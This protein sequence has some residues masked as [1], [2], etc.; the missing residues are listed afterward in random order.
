MLFK[1]QT[2]PQAYFHPSRASV[3]THNY[4]VSSKSRV[5]P[6]GYASRIPS[7]KLPLST[8]IIH[9]SPSLDDI[10]TSWFFKQ[11]LTLSIYLFRG[12]TAERLPAHSSIHSINSP[13]IL[14]LSTWLSYRR[15]SSSIHPSTHFVFSHNSII[16]GLMNLRT[17]SILLIPSD[18]LK[19]PICTALILEFSFSFHINI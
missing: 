18:L 3:A 8:L 17:L 1:L 10:Q 5:H 19:L 15:I 2:W 6:L 13:I 11:P 12:R 4:W 16:H 9:H 14:I 7:H